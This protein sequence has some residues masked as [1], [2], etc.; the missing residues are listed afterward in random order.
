MRSASSRFLQL[1]GSSMRLLDP[2]FGHCRQEEQ[3]G[4]MGFS[5][6]KCECCR[7]DVEL[8]QIHNLMLR[9]FQ[10]VRYGDISL[11]A[12]WGVDPLGLDPIPF[13]SQKKTKSQ[14]FMSD[15]G[16]TKRQYWSKRNCGHWRVFSLSKQC[17]WDKQLIETMAA[18]LMTSDS[19]QLKLTIEGSERS[20]R[21]DLGSIDTDL[22]LSP[23][24]NR[25]RQHQ[26]QVMTTFASR[27]YMQAQ[28]P[29]RHLLAHFWN[30]LSNFD[31]FEQFWA[32]LSNFEPFCAFFSG[33]LGSFRAILSIFV[34]QV[35]VMSSNSEQFLGT[36][37]GIVDL[38][39]YSKC[40]N[41]GCFEILLWLKKVADVNPTDL[42]PKTRWVN[43]VFW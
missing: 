10:R 3:G 5:T 11:F 42:D 16:I 4:N 12:I 26:C 22:N 33:Q 38:G 18:N 8:I 36:R 25:H 40:V 9:N 20:S 7:C 19:C 1:L 2:S 39:L 31:N 27:P 13:K 41:W 21:H 32:T 14:K 28:H 30:I 29:F 43:I 24:K 35:W 6:L 17:W 37:Y 34:G 15:C 23:C